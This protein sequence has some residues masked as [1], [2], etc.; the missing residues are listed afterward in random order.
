MRRPNG[1]F[2]GKLFD[3]LDNVY[4]VTPDRTFVPGMTQ[5]NVGPWNLIQRPD[6][7]YTA[8]A[9]AS[10]DFPARSRPMPKSWR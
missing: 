1:L 8:R 9:F 7:R 2:P 3:D 6:K 5:F 10:F 4:Q